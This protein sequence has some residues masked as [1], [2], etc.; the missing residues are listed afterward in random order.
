MER[1]RTK[2]GICSALLL[3]FSLLVLVLF[4]HPA[5]E[6][7]MIRVVERKSDAKVVVF[8][9]DRRTDADLGVFVTRY[10]IDANGRDAFWKYVDRQ[11][12]ADTTV[13]FTNYRNDADVVVFFVHH[14]IDAK[15]YRSNP[16]QGKFHR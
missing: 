1:S 13:Y 3:V 10:T 7:G 6:A 15:W 4:F 9:T 16:F 5:A 12:D 14:T 2:K 11:I 8:V